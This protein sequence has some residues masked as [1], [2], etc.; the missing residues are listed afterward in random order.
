MY[1][2]VFKQ[3]KL[4]YLLTFSLRLS[5][6]PFPPPSCLGQIFFP[7]GFPDLAENLPVLVSVQV[8]HIEQLVLVFVPIL[9]VLHVPDLERE[10]V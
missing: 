8:Y 6:P 5:P 4:N 10:E 9:A 1:K 2:S 3:E 7:E